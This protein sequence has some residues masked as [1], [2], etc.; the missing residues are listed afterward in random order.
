MSIFY[1][2]RHADPLRNSSGRPEGESP[3]SDRGRRD[4]E[5][6]ASGFVAVELD[7]IYSSPYR[8]AR[9]TVEPIARAKGLSIRE[10]QNFRER[11]L[12]DGPFADPIFLSAV[13]AT[14]DDFGFIHPGGESNA[15]AQKRA[16]L[17]L[18]E[19]LVRHGG[20]PIAISTHATLLALIVN[21]FDQS[22]GFEFWRQITM[23]DLYRLEIHDNRCSRI[24][25]IVPNRSHL[26]MRPLQN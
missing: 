4:A 12:G 23:P 6:L 14:W 24:E 26:Q 15:S 18:S 8:R 21:S 17:A 13:R 7:A 11:T 16:R 22:F 20:R 19:L 3:L 9:E 5:Q 1:L 10:I 2:I 25:R